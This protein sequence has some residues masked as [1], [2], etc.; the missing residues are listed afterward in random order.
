MTRIDTSNRIS[1][2]S[3]VQPVVSLYDALWDPVAGDRPAAISAPRLRVNVQRHVCNGFNIADLSESFSDGG[4]REIGADSGGDNVP[5]SRK[6]K[7]VHIQSTS[8]HDEGYYYILEETT[9]RGADEVGRRVGVRTYKAVGLDW[10]LGRQQVTEAVVSTATRASDL[11]AGRRIGRPQVFNGADPARTG[12]GQG[13]RGNKG[14]GEHQFRPAEEHAS[15]YPT[16]WC[17]ADADY[18]NADATIAVKLGP[19]VQTPVD[20]TAAIPAAP[21]ALTQQPNLKIEG[22]EFDRLP[23]YYDPDD[24]TW[25][26]DY[27]AGLEWDGLAMIKYLLA[28]EAPQSAGSNPLPV[29]YQVNDDA[30]TVAAL[31]AVT[32]TIQ[33]DRR[34]VLDLINEIASSRRGLQW[35]GKLDASPLLDNPPAQ[36]VFKIYVR[37]QSR[38]DVTLPSGKIFPANAQKIRIQ[39]DDD[40]FAQTQVLTSDLSQRYD[41]VEFYGARLTTTFTVSIEDGTLV[42]DWSDEDE[43]AYREGAINDVGY[44]VAT[45]ERKAANDARRAELRHGGVYSAFRIPADWDGLSGDGSAGFTRAEAFPVISDNG[46]VTGSH[47]IFLPLLRPERLTRIPARGGTLAGGDAFEP[48]FA[49]VEVD[50]QWKFTHALTDRA[51][52]PAERF[53]SY[54]L[55]GAD[56]NLGVR[57]YS[58]KS[59]AHTLAGPEWLTPRTLPVGVTPLPQP[60]PSRADP[61]IDYKKIR[62][63]MAAEGDVRA[64][65][66]YGTGNEPGTPQQ[67]LKVFAGDD[68]R[69]DYIAKGTI[70]GITAGVLDTE[71]NARVLRDDRPAL[72]ALATAAHR[73]YSVPR[74]NLVIQYSE[75]AQLPLSIGL[76]SYVTALGLDNGDLAS[77]QLDREGPPGTPDDPYNP[78]TEINTMIT[79]LTF[80]YGDTQQVTVRTT[81]AAIPPPLEAIVEGGVR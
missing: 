54:R 70:T 45:D 48:A 40:H 32:P 7:Y 36:P 44:P 51:A 63:T 6:G 3:A 57:L 22:R 1:P 55:V 49:V 19:V 10:F 12:D 23:A 13:S 31:G 5:P 2:P 41:R 74:R 28:N 33:T 39:S 46:S 60:S 80:V 81:G 71:A 38:T 4:V 42:I 16:A 79:S 69:L 75:I 76:G 62:V 9:P 15:I 66:I 24:S 61:E 56:G 18:T 37:S 30:E 73:W 29:I 78:P 50:S 27:L 21:T 59:L 20:W 35:F 58:S 47:E 14:L 72:E 68:Y 64:V 34:T 53:A 43:R 11:P 52:A 77:G 17:V 26:V 67:T 8:F 65:G 25:K